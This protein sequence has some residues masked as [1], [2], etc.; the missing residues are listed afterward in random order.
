[1]KSVMLAAVAASVLTGCATPYDPTAYVRIYGPEPTKEQIEQAKMDL[2]KCLYRVA[3][4]VDDGTSD[5]QTIGRAVAGQCS[6]HS[7]EFAR[8]R[9]WPMTD[10]QRAEYYRG[11]DTLQADLATTAVLKLRAEQRR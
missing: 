2:V 10:T 4:T 1:M 6:S 8:L 9:T 11:W 7:A 3:P 5:A